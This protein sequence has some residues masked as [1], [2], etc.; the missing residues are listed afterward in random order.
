MDKFSYIIYQLSRSLKIKYIFKKKKE[1]NHQ[2]EIILDQLV[3][4]MMNKL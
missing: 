4:V 1:A 2:V 3:W